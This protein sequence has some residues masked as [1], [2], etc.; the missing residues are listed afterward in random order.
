MQGLNELRSI[1]TRLCGEVPLQGYARWKEEYESEQAKL[2]DAYDQK[3][4][5]EFDESQKVYDQKLKNELLEQAI[6]LRKE[7]SQ[8]VKDQV[9]GEPN[10]DAKRYPTR[11]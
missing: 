4:K 11:R 5:A 3:L 8:Q 9:E 7:F 2:K 10:H 6:A 1:A